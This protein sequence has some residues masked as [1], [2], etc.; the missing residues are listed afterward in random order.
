MKASVWATFLLLSAQRTSVSGRCLFANQ[1]QHTFTGSQAH[2]RD[3]ASFSKEAFMIKNQASH[4]TSIEASINA[5]ATSS[6]QT[7]ISD[8]A[9]SNN[10]ASNN[11]ESSFSNEAVN[12]QSPHNQTLIHQ[13]AAPIPP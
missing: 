8:Q 1:S 5:R 10:E 13:Q 2:A 6:K 12:Q 11:Q 7:I 9:S 4:N 3:Q